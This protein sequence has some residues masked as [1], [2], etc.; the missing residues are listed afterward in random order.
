MSIYFPDGR[1]HAI[2]AFDTTDKGI[3]FFEPQTD[4][5]VD[6]QVGARYH[7]SVLPQP[8]HTYLSPPYEDSVVRYAIIW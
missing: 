2:V 8:G 1:G 6:L 5:E 4:D 3:V 7:Q